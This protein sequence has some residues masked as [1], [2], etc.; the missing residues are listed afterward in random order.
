MKHDTLKIHSEKRVTFKTINNI[1]QS[2]E[3]RRW[4]EAGEAAELRQGA[5]TELLVCVCFSRVVK[6]LEW[7][8]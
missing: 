3:G 7:L 4:G 1:S 2:A 5:D 8:D 6:M